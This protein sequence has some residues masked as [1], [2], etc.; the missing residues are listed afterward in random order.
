[1]LRRVSLACVQI[2]SVEAFILRED[3]EFISVLFTD[4]LCLAKSQR[5]LI[6]QL[7]ILA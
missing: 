5:C 1:M 2:S 6:V 4:C 7:L 3:S